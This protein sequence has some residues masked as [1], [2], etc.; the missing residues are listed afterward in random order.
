MPDFDEYRPPGYERRYRGDK[1]KKGNGPRKKRGAGA[2]D[3][4]REERMAMDF[5]FANYYGQPVVKAPPWEWPIGV[6][7]W[8][9]GIGGGS[10]LLGAGA[11]A[12]SNKP[13]LRTTRLTSI[14]AAG[15][16]S[17]FLIL[18]L[19]R[20]ERFYNMFRVF[21]ASS[22]MNM[23][24]WLLGGF[25]G[26]AAV[27]A[28]SEAAEM[29]K[30]VLPLPNVV[31]RVLHTAAGPAGIVS[32]VLGGPLAGYTAVLIADTSNPTWNGAKKHLPYV[33]VAS[34]SL[35]SAG[36]AMITTPVANAGPARALALAGVA[37]DLAMVRVMED[38]MEPEHVKHLKEGKP[39]KLMKAS[40]YLAI[41][42]GVGTA[43]ASVTKSRA[44]SVVAGG[45]LAAASLCTRLGVLEGGL[46]SAK[47]PE[48]TIGPQKRRAEARLRD[49]GL[50]NSVITPK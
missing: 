4:T 3:G 8:L 26:A 42:G 30:N 11:Q 14:V 25:S 47:D 13:L 20:P 31:H 2:Q 44:V 7:F 1:K 45:C 28:A 33:F 41:A 48:A 12:T 15:L 49:S 23:G 39:G 29:T 34:A 6:Y 22:P 43:L 17:A 37:G 50:T 19:G 32:A 38:N 16:G 21:K 18:D 27:A 35:A 9:G 36:T 5:Q 24:S 46:E 40:E 10:A